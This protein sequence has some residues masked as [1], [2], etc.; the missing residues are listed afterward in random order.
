MEKNIISQSLTQGTPESIQ[1]AIVMMDGTE[2]FYSSEYQ[3]AKK[4]YNESGNIPF[5][6]MTVHPL[7]DEL[8]ANFMATQGE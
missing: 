1:S 6:I 5:F 7:W 8:V 2:L 4:E 3:N